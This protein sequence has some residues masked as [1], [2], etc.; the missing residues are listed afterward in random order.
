MAPISEEMAHNV[1]RAAEN[2]QVAVQHA[3]NTVKKVQ[4]LDQAFE[5]MQVLG[6]VLDNSHLAADAA[7]RAD[8]AAKKA[9]EAAQKADA[10][11][12]KAE[13]PVLAKLAEA[14]KRLQDIEKRAQEAAAK[15]VRAAWIGAATEV[16]KIPLLLITLFLLLR[17]S[18]VPLNEL[19]ELTKDGVKFRTDTAKLTAQLE[20]HE[21]SIAALKAQLEALPKAAPATQQVQSPEAQQRLVEAKERASEDVVSDAT[22]RLA[23]T[24]EGGAS[25]L[26]S[27][28]TGYIWIGDLKPAGGGWSRRLLKADGQ[29]VD[30]DKVEV[31]KEYTL[32]GNP[33]LRS[34]Q[35]PNTEGY[36][37]SVPI[38]GVLPRGTKVIALGEPV[39]INREFAT[40]YWLNVQV[41]DPND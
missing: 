11:A 21:K 6:Q 4:H 35:P 15:G 34:G 16:L 33:V 22:A 18:G 13:A 28:T 37:R 30:G 23:K 38:N 36:F 27:E 31:D 3:E 1:L 7:R 39:P 8:E 5:K 32:N 17:I 26:L 40:Q 12:Q 29:L 25:L 9:D 10:A 20:S 2:A 41:V 14:E 24:G 19:A